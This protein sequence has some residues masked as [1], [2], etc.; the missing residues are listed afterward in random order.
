M[1]LCLKLCI[2]YSWVI[3]RS[4][5][6]YLVYIN[7]KF[8]I[9][10]CFS[11][12]KTLHPSS[13]RYGNAPK[14]IKICFSLRFLSSPSVRHSSVHL[15]CEGQSRTEFLSLSFPDIFRTP[16]FF[17]FF[18]RERGQRLLLSTLQSQQ[19][20]FTTSFDLTVLP[21]QRDRTRHAI[22]PGEMLVPMC[23][24][25]FQYQSLCIL[26]SNLDWSSQE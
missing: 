18:L 8:Y 23:L 19:L 21:G 4:W 22:D 11:F 16:V 1:S 17:R 13:L 2:S 3:H 14:L 7:R 10:L 9:V 20:S 6:I 12:Y 26:L 25:S 5:V 24:L 15:I